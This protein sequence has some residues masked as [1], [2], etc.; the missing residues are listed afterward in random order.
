MKDESEEF[1]C[2]THPI[3]LTSP[4]RQEQNLPL[5]HKKKKQPV[6]L[7]P[8]DL[9]SAFF[10]LLFSFP[11]GFVLQS[12]FSTVAVWSSLQTANRFSTIESRRTFYVYVL[13]VGV[14][15]HTKH[16][17]LSYRNSHRKDGYPHFEKSAH[18]TSPV[19]YRR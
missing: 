3:Y 19:F 16:K 2:H 4:V 15:N 13:C 14:L 6:Q 12:Y 17:S 9:L 10:P 7:P 11:S 8:P 18:H 5:G 1:S